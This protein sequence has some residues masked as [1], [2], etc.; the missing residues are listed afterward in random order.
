[1]N[2]H[3]TTVAAGIVVWM[4]CLGVLRAETIG[5][6]NGSFESPATTYV[7][8]RVNLWQKSPKP[9]S[10]DESGGFL[11]DQL[12]G[13]FLNTPPASADHLD[14]CE[15][16][17]AVYL[18][19][20]PQVALFQDY[21]S[22]DW[23]HTAP[24][25][26]FEA[27]FEVGKS[28][29][30]T[31]GINGGGGG[32]P[33]GSSF[34]ISLYYRDGVSNLVTVAATTITN[35]L[36]AF[37]NRT[38]LTDYRVHVRTV[39]TTDAWTGRHIGVRLLS[40]VSADLQGGYWDLDNVRLTTLAEPKFAINLAAESSGLRLSWPSVVGYQYQVNISEDLVA[41]SDYDAPLAGTGGEL[42]EL[43]PP[44]GRPRSFFRVQAAL[45]P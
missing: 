45:A 23:S 16:R 19:A 6:P 28:Y 13:V 37:P 14:N 4:T 24:L 40:T 32:M 1:M 7:I 10:Y 44:A 25:H 27:T 35:S 31:V 21:D 41:W 36:D 39:Q 12:A 17:Q 20:V 2:R 8:P 30:L 15:A 3:L 5:V 38:H 34:E 9:D 26:A 33:V 18:F 43:I 22:T 29:D 11:W 42:S